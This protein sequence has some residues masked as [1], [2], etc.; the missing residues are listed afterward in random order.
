MKLKPIQRKIAFISDERERREHYYKILSDPTNKII[1]QS[2][3]EAINQVLIEE[4]LDLVII[5]AAFISEL[6][7]RIIE[8]I[9]SHSKL[10]FIIFIF[11]LNKDQISLKRQIYKNPHNK[12][13]VE[14]VDKYAFLSLIN[15]S[16]YMGTLEKRIYLY[17]DII[18]GEKRLISYMDDLLELSRLQEYK[19][20]KTLF[21]HLQKEFV[22]RLELAMAVELA[23]VAF[24][25]PSNN[26]LHFQLLDETKHVTI[27]KHV[28]SLKK[29][30]VG[31]L[32][33]ENMPKIFEHHFLIDSFV[34]ELEES[35]GFKI[36]GL[37]L[38]PIVVL[39]EPR[40]ALILVNKVYRTEFSENDLSFVMIASHKIVHHLEAIS[41]K[42]LKGS[43]VQPGP[44]DRQ[45]IMRYQLFEE[46][47]E[48]VNFGIVVFDQED[49]IG[50]LNKEAREL[51]KISGNPKKLNEI[52]D[53]NSYQQ[54]KKTLSE[55]PLPIKREEFQIIIGEHPGQYFGYSVY[56]IREA[57]D[58]GEYVLIFSEISQT[59]RIQA[60]IIRMDRMASLGILSSGIAHEIRNPL[61]GIKAMAQT[62][63]EELEEESHLVEYVERILRQVNRLEGL[64]KTFFTYAKPQR[65]N[66]KACHIENII[67]EVLPLF[68]RKLKEES[69]VIK[70]KYADDLY[71]I[72]VDSSQIE[73]VVFNLIIN[74]IQAMKE[75]GSISI[76]AQNADNHLPTIDRRLRA[77]GL[78]SDKYIE[79]LISDDGPGIPPDIKENIFNPFFTT[80][81]N[82]TGLGL[83]IVYQIVR[84]HGGQIDV[85]SEPDT[86]TDFSIL[87]PAVINNQN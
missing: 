46:L 27:K 49:E 53:E 28:I 83:S 6:D 50:Y 22:K 61:A 3:N 17:E 57:Q 40:A 67:K 37:L 14:P 55:K 23:L 87:L 71:E 58:H 2:L 62:L 42:Y 47:L 84:E 56:P 31:R 76:V 9:R 75:G 68:E 52:L 86:G 36:S 32:L 41:L 8:P 18:E 59:K 54:F 1:A 48:S 10:A 15:S 65:P 77:P 80:K 79:I 24:Y 45:K 7:Y 73:Q 82:G 81:A 5:D 39:H 21:D 30:I 26:T 69:I 16:L 20:E 11:I 29:S 60:E 4:P 25:E 13:L 34:Q 64:L 51:L 70:Q 85:Q 19:R 43:K 35:L 74:S 38:V 63:E 66:P 72:F 78:L 33:K 12:I 44:H